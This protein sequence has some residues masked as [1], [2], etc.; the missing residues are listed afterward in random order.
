MIRRFDYPLMERA[1]FV[2]LKGNLFDFAIRKTSVISDAFRARYLSRPGQEGMFEARAIVFDGSD[3]YH[4]RI[5][6]PSLPLAD[7]CI[8]VTPRSGVTGRPG[9]PEVV[10]MQPPAEIIPQGQ[11]WPPP[12]GAGSPHG[13]SYTAPTFTFAPPP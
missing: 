10:N 7:D 2:V 4:H 13:S 5:N 11:M 3:D 9:S 1:G 8:L 12:L 6:D